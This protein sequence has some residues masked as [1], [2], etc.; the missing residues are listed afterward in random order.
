MAAFRAVVDPANPPRAPHLL[1]H[2]FWSDDQAEVFG[3]TKALEE[4]GYHIDT[5]A[6]NPDRPDRMWSVVA[7]KLDLLEERRILTVSDQLDELARQFGATYGGWVT[8]VE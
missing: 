8:R 3:L 6:Y 4:Q 7:V 1:E 5:F 2:H